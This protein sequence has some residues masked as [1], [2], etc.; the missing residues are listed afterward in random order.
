[1]IPVDPI[2]VLCG[3]DEWLTTE[4]LGNLESLPKLLTALNDLIGAPHFTPERIGK[5]TMHRVTSANS[6]TW[7]RCL[8]DRSTPLAHLVVRMGVA[9]SVTSPIRSRFSGSEPFLPAAAGRSHFRATRA[10]PE[11]V[12]RTPRTRERVS[13]SRKTRTATGMRTTAA[14]PFTAT[15]DH[16]RE[17]P[18]R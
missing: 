3:A 2:A 5:S 1:M 13:C 8:R 16:C 6:V 10:I 11:T 4:S 14:M 9:L 15:F 7:L 12:S 18:E 17:A